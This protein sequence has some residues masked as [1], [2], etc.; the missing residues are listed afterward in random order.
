MMNLSTSLKDV[1]SFLVYPLH[2]TLGPV[3][4]SDGVA[5]QLVQRQKSIL[6]I[7]DDHLILKALE[8]V[9]IKRGFQV[10]IAA[11]GQEGV[12]VFQAYAEHI[13]IILSDVQM[14]TL[15]GPDAIKVICRTD[16]QV[17]FCFMTGDSRLATQAKL[18]DLGAL[19]VFAKPFSSL[20][21]VAEELWHL[22]ET[23]KAISRTNKRFDLNPTKPTLNVP[24]SLSSNDDMDD[25]SEMKD[26]IS[27]LITY[28]RSVLNRRKESTRH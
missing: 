12:D 23:P 28:A 19:Q 1:N 9:L 20:K 6:V 21:S 25:E 10:W 3:V 4:D 24:E 27:R 7:E 18:L 5:P 17:R 26:F 11:N 14:P 8:Q 15:D 13:D 22:A 16:P 2:Q